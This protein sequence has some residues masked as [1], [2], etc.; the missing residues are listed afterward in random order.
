MPTRRSKRIWSRRRGQPRLRLVLAGLG[1]AAVALALGLSLPGRGG[2]TAATQLPQPNGKPMLVSFIDTQAQPSASGNASRSQLVFIK[3]MDTQSHAAGLR[4]V[5]VDTAHASANALVNF[6][7]DWSLPPR[8]RVL[9]DPHGTLAHAYGVVQVPTTVLLGG[10][11]ALIGRWS[12]FA[13]AAQLD[14]AVRRATGRR[15][16]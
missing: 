6:R 8:I 15:A 5:I 2:S 4:T 16:F 1:I 12:G 3:S 11:G 13:S 9:A 14:F 10:R 7:Y